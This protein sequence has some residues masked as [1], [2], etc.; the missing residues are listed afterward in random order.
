MAEAG[1]PFV[2]NDGNEAIALIGSRSGDEGNPLLEEGIGG[3][4]AAGLS[5]LARG[6]MAIIAQ[7][8]I[9]EDKVRGGGFVKGDPKGSGCG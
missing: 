2:K 7:I 8:G 9:D 4:E 6:V 1:V 5:V 3:N